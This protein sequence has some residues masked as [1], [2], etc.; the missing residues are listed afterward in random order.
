MGHDVRIFMHYGMLP[1]K[2]EIPKSGLVGYAMFQS[3]SVYERPAWY[4]VPLYLFGHHC[5]LTRRIYGGKMK[6]GGLLCLLMGSWVCWNYWKPE[7]TATTGTGMIPVW[8][9]ISRYKYCIH[10]SQSC[11]SDRG[12]V[13]GRITWCPWYCR[14]I[15]QWQLRCSLPIALTPFPRLMRHRSRHRVRWK[16]RRLAVFHQW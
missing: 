9:P 11:L 12:A 4:D 16:A 8:M 3:F 15:T 5:V 14:V 13:L 7:I 1:D 6:T 10:D 2:M